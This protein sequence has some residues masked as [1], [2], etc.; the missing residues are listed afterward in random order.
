MKP[1]LLTVCPVF[2]TMAVAGLFYYSLWSLLTYTMYREST[3]M[4][5]KV[6]CIQSFLREKAHEAQQAYCFQIYS[7]P[8]AHMGVTI[9]EMKPNSRCG[10]CLFALPRLVVMCLLQ[11][12]PG[13]T[14]KYCFLGNAGYSVLLSIFRLRHHPCCLDINWQLMA[15]TFN[16]Q[17]ANRF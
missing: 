17:F 16:R 15:R 6:Y 10:C 8:N 11:K 12:K 1:L 13:L 9:S 7:R 14:L 4:D 2:C 5:W 3:N